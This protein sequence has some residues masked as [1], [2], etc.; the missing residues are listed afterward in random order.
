MEGT[1]AIMNCLVNDPV[2][3]VVFERPFLAVVA[4]IHL[5]LVLNV[6]VVL[7]RFAAS[8]FRRC[9]LS[10]RIVVSAVGTGENVGTQ[11]AVPIGACHAVA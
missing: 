8:T 6:T 2:V 3:N 7:L 11:V 5:V 9:Y 4:I 1:P 10:L